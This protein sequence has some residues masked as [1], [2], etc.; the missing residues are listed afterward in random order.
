[1]PK[2][3]ESHGFEGGP[4]APSFGPFVTK[5]KIFL[6]M[7]QGEKGALYVKRDKQDGGTWRQYVKTICRKE[8]TDEKYNRDFLLRMAEHR[9]KMEAVT[10]EME[11]RQRKEDDSV[12]LVL[13][14][15][16][17]M[18]ESV[19]VPERTRIS[20]VRTK[21][22]ELDEQGK[23]AF[24]T[25][26][27]DACRSR[28]RTEPPYR[29]SGLKWK[30]VGPEKPPMGK[31]IKNDLLKRALAEKPVFKEDEW[32]AFG[33]GGGDKTFG[34]TFEDFVLVNGTYFRPDEEPI[35]KLWTN[36]TLQKVSEWK[37]KWFKMAN[38]QLDVLRMF[39][40]KIGPFTSLAQCF[41]SS[42]SAIDTISQETHTLETLLVRVEH[43]ED[44]YSYCI[45]YENLVHGKKS[46]DYTHEASGMTRRASGEFADERKKERVVNLI[47]FPELSNPSPPASEEAK[48]TIPV[49]RM[50]RLVDMPTSI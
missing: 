23:L 35:W 11:E 42:L 26:L 36:S 43:T 3:C 30:E 15:Y 49:C 33:V 27:R 38:E 28:E 7:R 44:N 2:R 29:P 12:R 47:F 34:L 6:L 18:M 4:D 32:K 50:K 14:Q 5:P 40:V 25:W 1:M 19:D 39:N 17:E 13:Q 8:M 41:P 16:N 31:E 37:V 10:R 48:R 9:R 46:S 20:T 24:A 21:I 22:E 45:P